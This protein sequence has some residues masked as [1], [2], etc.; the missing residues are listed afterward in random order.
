MD[1]FVLYMIVL[2]ME[3]LVLLST[4]YFLTFDESTQMDLLLWLSFFS[5]TPQP[6]L[7]IFPPLC[8]HV[9]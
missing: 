7:I 5:Y 1:F 2:Y 4:F 9:F 3:S 8:I 6:N